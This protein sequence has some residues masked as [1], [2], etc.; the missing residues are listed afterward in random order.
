MSMLSDLVDSHLDSYE[1]L[2]YEYVVIYKLRDHDTIEFVE[3][4]KNWDEYAWA[5]RYWTNQNYVV[6]RMHDL[7]YRE[8]MRKFDE[9]DL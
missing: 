6:S 3:S 4:Y 1:A 7:G 8:Y 2:G 5:R 9:A